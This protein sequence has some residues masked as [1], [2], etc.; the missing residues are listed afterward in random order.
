MSCNVVVLLSLSHSSGEIQYL[1]LGEGVVRFGLDGCG[2][3][4]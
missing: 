1:C 2:C 4:C 3:A